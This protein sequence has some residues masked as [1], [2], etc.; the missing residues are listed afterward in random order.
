M[1]HPALQCPNVYAVPQMFC[2]E[3]VAELVQEEMP[4]VRP[5][6]TFISML[7]KTLSAV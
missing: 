2:C 3:S 5:F 1:A 7:G 6:G 4:A